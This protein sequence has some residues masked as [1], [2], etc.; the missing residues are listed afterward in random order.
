MVAT[1][2]QVWPEGQWQ[3]SKWRWYMTER[4][5]CQQ[6]S[7]TMCFYIGIWQTILSRNVGCQTTAWFINSKT[8][9]VKKMCAY[10]NENKLNV[11]SFR[12]PVF[13][14]SCKQEVWQWTTDDPISHSFKAR[15][16][17]KQPW[18]YTKSRS[19][20]GEEMYAAQS[21]KKSD[22]LHLFSC[23]IAKKSIL[24]WQLCSQLRYERLIA[25]KSILTN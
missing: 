4:R 8:S 18:F 19:D 15:T 14:A 10:Q 11:S 20:S 12:I 24:S 17:V 16:Q 7:C 1:W 13:P 2:L 21:T 25:F 22:I 5:V 6:D 23:F 3:R 9:D